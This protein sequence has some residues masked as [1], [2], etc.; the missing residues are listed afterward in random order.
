[1]N[2]E[3]VQAQMVAWL[4]GEVDGETAGRV[5]A[6]VQGCAD[7]AR[8]LDGVSRVLDLAG[9]RSAAA[10]VEPGAVERAR[11]KAQ[12][13]AMGVNF[14][15]LAQFKA[16]PDAVR[17]LDREL[18]ERCGLIAVQKLGQRLF[19][20][21]KDPRNV[22]ARDEVQRVTGMQVVAALATADDIDDAIRRYYEATEAAGPETPDPPG[23]RKPLWAGGGVCP[24]RPD[25]SDRS[26]A[27]AP[28]TRI[29]SDAV[30]MVDEATARRHG[31]IPVEKSG[32][33]LFVAMKDPHNAV[34]T[35]EVAR[36]TGMQVVPVPA[37]PEDVDLA[38]ASCFG[39]K[40]DPAPIVR[41]V[42][43]I[44]Q[45]ALRDGATDIHIEPAAGGVC[46]RFRMDGVLQEVM[47]LP[48]YL[49][50]P[51]L[52]RVKTMADMNIAEQ[53]RPQQGR[54]PV[55]YEGRDY[56]I[57]VSTFPFVEGEKAVLHVLP[58]GAVIHDW[59]KLGIREP[60]AGQL[61]ALLASG[62]GLL[63]VAGPTGSGKTT[64]LYGLCGGL[65]HETRNIVSVEDP[66]EYALPGV[67]QVAVNRRA[68]VT[69]PMAI[70]ELE[71]AGADVI[72]VGQIT[73]AEVARA[74]LEAAGAGRL[75]LATIHAEDALTALARLRS[76]KIPPYMLST[77]LAGV[78]GVRLARRVCRA[79]AADA[80]VTASEAAALGLSEGTTARSG[81]GCE[82]CRNTGYRGR[83]GIFELLVPNAGVRRALSAGTPPETIAVAAAEAG[84]RPMR[85]DAA[86]KV[87]AGVTSA[88][89]A[90]RVSPAPAPPFAEGITEA[91]PPASDGTAAA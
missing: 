57:R 67:T 63:L 50:A 4:Q 2:C 80:P 51:L 8:S 48:E 65:D 37:R 58:Q 28:L 72:L 88:A 23:E 22:I 68:G 82:E 64:V 25:L 84:M 86:A 20:A 39:T 11:A 47:R 55:T 83:I 78:V 14:V 85:A 62:A 40:P 73:C 1:M 9:G 60:Q 19:I 26:E 21:M 16:N 34:A 6:H 90:L 75:V 3:Q 53:R 5:A 79:C 27:P 24:D 91:P 52:H 38:I 81:A 42:N 33:R 56:D 10:T 13:L 49:H 76:W 59:E 41:V 71:A 74:A 18:A 44:L 30:H 46:V 77:G 45:Q 35:E 89:E 87:L 61:R 32:Q 43:S 15:D 66:V 31:L 54:I 70:R 12:A 36:A 29:H 69:A 17:T 7:C